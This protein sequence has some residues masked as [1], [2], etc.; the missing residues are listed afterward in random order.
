MHKNL[1]DMLQQGNKIDD[2]NAHLRKNFA[3]LRKANTNSEAYLRTRCYLIRLSR[4][5]AMAT[6]DPLKCICMLLAK[7]TY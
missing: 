4:A 2:L 5:M 7:A 6:Q 3:F 1:I